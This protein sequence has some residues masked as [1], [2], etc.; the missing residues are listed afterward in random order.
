MTLRFHKVSSAFVAPIWPGSVLIVAALVMGGCDSNHTGGPG[1]ADS[2]GSSG[3]DAAL[4]GGF[5]QACCSS[6]CDAPFECQARICRHPG[7]LAPMPTAR[8][9]LGGVADLDRQIYAIG[10]Y[11]G[12]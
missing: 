11:T 9:Y 12:S 8:A 5:A 10:G 7:P 6:Q 4:C 1:G 2:G 3:A